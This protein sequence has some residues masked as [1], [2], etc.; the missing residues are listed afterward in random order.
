V[1]S[2]ENAHSGSRALKVTSE[3]K[4]RG[5]GDAVVQITQPLIYGASYRLSY[6]YLPTTKAGRLQARL[7]SSEVSLSHPV[8][9]GLNPAPFTPGAPSAGERSLEK[10]R[11][12][13]LNEVQPENIAGPA[14][15]RGERLPFIEILSND[16]AEVDLTV[17][18]FCASE[19]ASA[20]K[21][22]IRSNEYKAFWLSPAGSAE[23]D[24]IKGKLSPTNGIA[25]LSR[26][27]D[28]RVLDYLRYRGVPRDFSHGAFPNGSLIERETFRRATPGAANQ[29][30]ADTLKLYITEWM[31]ANASSVAD[32]ADGKFQ[33]WFELYNP[34]AF[35]VYLEGYRLAK[36]LTG[37][38]SFVIPNG[39]LIPAGGYLVIWADNEPDQNDLGPQVHASFSLDRDGDTIALFSPLGRLIDSVTFGSQRENWS[40]GTL[41]GDPKGPVTQMP[42]SPGSA[43]QASGG[44]ARISISPSEG[45]R[46]V[47]RW[48]SQ[49]GARYV[50]QG[51]SRLGSGAG[52]EVLGSVS[53]TSEVTTWTWSGDSRQPAQ[54]FRLLY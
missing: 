36:S 10:F 17:Y 19:L 26:K 9:E 52:W 28:G 35:P 12:L 45:G 42:P 37:Q 20:L 23:P 32:P 11:E 51:R 22:V 39:K 4:S 29:R 21:G 6:W 15:G 24:G 38:G 43:N 48:D 8:F 5:A 46:Y 1:I 53:A 40:E 16:A 31:A 25:W 50:I 41:A 34:N 14:N 13:S 7:E 3:G 27:S 54:F 2:T 49:P 47:L 33:D 44:L 18:E 30:D